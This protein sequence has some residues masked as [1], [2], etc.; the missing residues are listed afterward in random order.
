MTPPSTSRVGAG[1]ELASGPR[2]KAEPVATSRRCRPAEG[3]D[4][5]DGGVLDHLPV[6]LGARAEHLVACRGVRMMPG[7]M[8][9]TRHRGGPPSPRRP[10]PAGGLPAWR[11]RR[12]LRSSAPPPARGSAGRAVGW[13]CSP[14][15]ALPWGSAAAACGRPRSRCARRRRRAGIT[16]PNSSGTTAVPYRS[17][18]RTASA[19][20]CT[21]ETP[22]VL[23]TW[24]T[25]P[26]LAAC[27]SAWIDSRSDTST[28]SVV[29]V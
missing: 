12:R 25:S 29:K 5:T 18:A 23:T 17:T 7:L 20:A 16:F 9:L 10:R 3:A 15:H 6:A 24:T 19:D 8:E 1:D 13:A 26:G 21:G 2:R 14:G 27:A 22:A 4:P 11:L 28:R